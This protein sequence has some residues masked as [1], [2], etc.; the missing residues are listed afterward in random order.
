MRGAIGLDV[1]SVGDDA[2]R[3]VDELFVLGLHVDHEVPVYVAE[4][5]HG[6]GTEH[7]EDELGGGAGLH[8]GGAGKHFGAGQ[9]FDGYVD[10]RGEFGVR[11][12][13]EAE[14]GGTEFAGFVDSTEDVRRA[15][16]GGDADERVFAGEAVREQVGS[17]G[18]GLIF[19]AFGGPD[20]RGFATGDDADDGTRLDVEGGDPLAG[21]EHAEASTGAGTDVEQAATGFQ[22]LRDQID[23]GSDRGER[24]GYG[25]G[26]TSIFVVDETGH[27]EGREAVDIGGSRVALFGE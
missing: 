18:G 16:T 9:N 14:G 15:A 17:S 10:A 21:I 26:A 3:A 7:V 23:T 1:A 13:T 5:N 22:T 27:L 25:F 19:A 12:A 11:T 2:L 4:L 8:A 6:S 20:E 24:L